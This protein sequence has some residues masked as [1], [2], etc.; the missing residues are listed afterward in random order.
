[1]TT[2]NFHSSG[3]KGCEPPVA[4]NLEVAVKVRQFIANQDKLYGI[5]D[6]ATVYYMVVSNN[7]SNLKISQSLFA[8]YKASQACWLQC[9][10]AAKRVD[11]LSMGFKN[12]DE[13]YAVCISL[14]KEEKWPGW[15]LNSVAE[16]RKR[17]PNFKKALKGEV[18]FIKAYESLLSKKI[19]NHYAQK[20]GSE[21][22]EYLLTTFIENGIGFKRVLE[23]Y[24]EKADQMIESGQWK[25]SETTYRSISAIK[26][27]FNKPRIKQLWITKWSPK[28]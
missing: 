20:I 19:G 28:M 4:V 7:Y 10:A 5:T 6:K 27:F 3:F 18:T 16:L 15:K 13:F 25:E 2:V 21:Q 23:L 26:S 9:L 17:L 1:M 24:N 8:L 22:Q 14:M 12:T 11:Y